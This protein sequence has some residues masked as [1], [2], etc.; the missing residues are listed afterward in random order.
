MARWQDIETAEPDFAAKVKASFDAHRHKIMATLRRDGSPRVSGIEV[1]FAEG[2]VWIGSMTGS[3]KTADL[4]RD[5]RLAIHAG[6]DDPPED[7]TTWLGDAKLSGR[8]VE[9]DDPERLRSMAEGDGE[10]GGH[11]YRIELSEVV[12]TAVGDPPDHL[13]VQIWQEGSG[14][15]ELRTS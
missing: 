6:S 7:P 4:A 3:R 8:A 11:L 10:A 13:R 14:L 2:D 5:S 9:V 15:R 12:F 1:T